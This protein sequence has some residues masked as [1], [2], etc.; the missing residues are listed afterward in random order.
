MKK[1]YIIAFAVILVSTIT[2]IMVVR[3]QEPNEDQQETTI[4]DAMPN[5][6][7][8]QDSAITQLMEDHWTGRVRGEIEMQGWR[9]QIYSSNN[10]LVAKQEAEALKKQLE[11]ELTEPIY[12]DFIQ[13]FWKVRIGNFRTMEEARTYR[14]QLVQQFP[15]LQ[16]ESYPVRDVIKIKQ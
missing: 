5:A 3:A 12:M 16:A 14:N 9:V 1:G 15:E 13:P 7:I 4:L 2:A 6:T 11:N 10:Q 8:Y